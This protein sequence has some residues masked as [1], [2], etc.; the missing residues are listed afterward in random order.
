M[1][2]AGVTLLLVAGAAVTGAWSVAAT[3]TRSLAFT[4]GVVPQQVAVSVPP[5]HEACQTPIDVSESFASVRMEVGTYGSEGPQVG[6]IVRPAG[7][8]GILSSGRLAPG[9]ADNSTQTVRVAPVPEGRRV[10]VCIQN[11]GNSLVALYGGPALAARTSTATLD[12]QTLPSDISLVFLRQHKARLIGLL[13]VVFRRAALFH[14]TW[15]NAWVFWLLG[16]A[17]LLVPLLLAMAL[18]NSESR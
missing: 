16:G 3:D 5:G 17:L 4:L 7:E 12:G 10:A 18:S 6:L 9:Y 8:R 2:K 1:S 14:P 13:P 15:V 11:R